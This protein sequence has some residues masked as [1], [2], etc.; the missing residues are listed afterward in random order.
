M[1]SILVWWAIPAVAVTFAAV[2]AATARRIRRTRED[3][4]TLD[5][6]QRARETL[7]R[8]QHRDAQSEPRRPAAD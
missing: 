2:V 4:G 1:L 7:A 8:T 5:R 3:V 6:Y